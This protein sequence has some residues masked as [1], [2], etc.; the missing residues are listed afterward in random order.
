M[1]PLPSFLRLLPLAASAILAGA[2]AALANPFCTVEPGVPVPKEISDAVRA[3]PDRYRF[4]YGW[5]EKTRQ[6]RLNRQAIAEGKLRAGAD[7]VTATSG[8]LKLPVLLTTFAGNTS[9][10][11]PRV[12]Y[13]SVLFG[14]TGTG[15]LTDY[16]D[17][18]SYGLLALEGTVFDWSPVAYSSS[19]YTQGTGGLE[20]KYFDEFLDEIYTNRDGT[21]DFGQF[22]NDGPDG[23]P[24]SGDDDGVVDCVV[25][26]NENRA[27][28]CS[29]MRN[30]WPHQSTYQFTTNDLSA[31]GG[32]IKIEDY[33]V[34]AGQNCDG[35]MIN[36]ATLAHEL[37]HCLGAPDLYDRV[38]QPSAGSCKADS[39]SGIGAWGVMGNQTNPP[40]HPCAWTKAL[41]GWSTPVQVASDLISTALVSHTKY[42]GASYRLWSG[43]AAALEYFLVEVRTQEGF[44]A[45]LP[46]SG[47]V[48]YHIDD[49]QYALESLPNGDEC[50]PLIDV[51]CADQTA[52]DHTRNHDDLAA[53]L[54]A[55]AG[56]LWV[57]GDSFDN[58]SFPQPVSYGGALTDV[59]VHVET[60]D[61]MTET[62]V[63]T[64]RVGVSGLGVDLCIRDYTGDVCAENTSAQRWWT[65]PDIWIDNDGDG[66][67]D[68]P[69]FGATN[70]FYV[71]VHNNGVDSPSGVDVTLYYGD[72]G[73]GALVAGNMI[74]L[75]STKI[76]QIDG[77]SEQIATMDV[78][79]AVPSQGDFC[80]AAVV[81]HPADFVNLA[82]FP[83]ED[84][85]IAIRNIQQFPQQ[86][87]V[88]EPFGSST[89]FFDQR[90]MIVIN[91]NPF[92][93]SCSLEIIVDPPPLTYVPSHWA[94][95]FSPF[96]FRLGPGGKDTVHV[97]VS[98]S[99]PAHGDSVVL[100]LRADCME[101]GDDIGGDVMKWYIDDLPPTPP[102]P[103][104]AY[105]YVDKQGDGD[106]GKK[107]VMLEWQHSGN[108]IGSNPERVK[109][110]EIHRASIPT[111]VP[112]AMTLQ[113]TIQKD[114]M[115][116]DAGWHVF[117]DAPPSLPQY[118]K[119]YAV[120]WANNVSVASAAIQLL[121]F[122]PV[123]PTES[124]DL[125]PSTGTAV[126]P[127]PASETTWISFDVKR[128]GA[129]RV[130][131]YD[132]RGRLVRSYAGRFAEGRGRIV[133][134]HRDSSGRAVAN[135]TY[136][137]RITA[138]GERE[139]RKVTVLR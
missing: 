121:V 64:L 118:Y 96:A 69:D 27:A 107:A 85:N 9:G 119:I 98:S 110:W 87:T 2:A 53:N 136:L 81:S 74:Q 4:H 82:T 122:P 100:S 11:Y 128:P 24:N 91:N 105:L 88:P 109:R 125:S 123:P 21:I 59:E 72:P 70:R 25:I 30:I 139:T 38:E 8:V 113:A 132:L 41:F 62:Y 47:V 65:S 80:Y 124:P 129:S 36:I 1:R 55:D 94:Y 57:A 83:Y 40:Q 32:K 97:Y 116:D 51:E 13:E 135:G 76:P 31:S 45:S 120:D 10:P 111:F 16:Y 12:A 130:E 46:G 6:A 18:V 44:D 19:Y 131:I 52:S 7:V 115:P 22:D 3:N 35:T 50:H 42:P 60:F 102:L 75:A 90:D 58:T 68:A 101:L 34:V 23:V 39:A 92:A 93:A 103:G 17:E 56:D 67:E 104:A 95:D 15:T 78:D 66:V 86:S 26:V 89:S 127:N 112:S 138:G 48:I 114:E 126:F 79:L 14:L 108:D 73:I 84:N 33:V 49:L 137:A 63:A 5:T 133:W 106:F 28:Y 61:T 43:G 29:S 20:T 134:D 99:T 54:P 77:L 71:R 117:L 37:G